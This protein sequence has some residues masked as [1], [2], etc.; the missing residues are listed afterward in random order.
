MVG[1]RVSVNAS[2]TGVHEPL[3]SIIMPLR[4]INAPQTSRSICIN[5][6]GTIQR[7]T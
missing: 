1:V 6:H 2:L 4:H 5:E 3:V 7:T